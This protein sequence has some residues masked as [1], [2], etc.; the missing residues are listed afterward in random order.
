MDN[1][2]KNILDQ[3]ESLTLEFKSAFGR[4]TIETLCAFANTR[5]GQVLV[6]VTDA[7]EITGTPL[8]KETLQQWVNRVKGSTYPAVIPDAEIIPHG[9]KKVVGLSVISNPIKPV[10][11]K[12][13]YYKRI[14]NANHLMEL[15]EI[16][17]ERMKTMNLSWDFAPDPGHGIEHISLDKVNLFIEKV[18]RYRESPIPDDPLT[19]LKK[20]DLFRE[21][22]ITFGCFQRWIPAWISSVNII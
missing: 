9:D 1:T 6:G 7:G 2:L 15:S 21:S 13:K 11:F 5:G 10:S 3:G 17:D 16:L 18:N 12:G 20:F 4:E 14:H 19:V 8:S 22:S